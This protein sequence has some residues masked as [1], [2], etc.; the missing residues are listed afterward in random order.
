MYLENLRTLAVDDNPYYQY[1]K[2]KIG[3]G[4]IGG[5]YSNSPDF[6]RGYGIMIRQ[7]KV[8]RRGQLGGGIGSWFSNLFRMAQPYL[9]SGLKSVLNVGS[10]IA[11]DVIDGENVKSAF[12]KRVKEKVSAVLPP[13]ISN[14]VNKT[15][16]SGKRRGGGRSQSAAGVKRGRCV[17]KKKKNKKARSQNSFPGLKLIP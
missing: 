2:S 16:G 5:I 13:Q 9:K 17:K 1:Y 12:K 10:D 15:I 7:S 11:N 14:L 6:Q 3:A 8:R 4:D